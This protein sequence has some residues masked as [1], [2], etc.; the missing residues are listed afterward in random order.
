MNQLN[1]Q[2]TDNTQETSFCVPLAV[3]MVLLILAGINRLNPLTTQP[4]GELQWVRWREMIALFLLTPLVTASLWD[5]KNRVHITGFLEQVYLSALIILAISMGLHEP[6]NALS[7]AARTLPP[8]ISATIIFW[9]NQLSHYTFF[10][11]F[12]IVS[13][14]LAYGQLR[15]PRCSEE[16][17][18]GL[19][20]I[21]LIGL[22]IAA[23]IFRHMAFEPTALDIAVGL[24]NLSVISLLWL[25]Y[26]VK[27]ARAPGVFCLTLAYALGFGLAWIKQLF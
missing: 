8:D 1:K 3:L 18:L 7:V 4:V 6:T 23:I 12:S 17:P 10:I 19:T 26:P 9:D 16:T 13:L 5:L 24:F 27:P 22:M 2:T 15:Q 14:L 25:R 11:G 21:T 20:A